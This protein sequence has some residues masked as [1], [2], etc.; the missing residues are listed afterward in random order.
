M[1]KKLRFEQQ[2]E[3]SKLADMRHTNIV[4]TRNAI[5]WTEMRA[6]FEKIAG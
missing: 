4:E 6:H 2:L 3:L 5:T 1:V